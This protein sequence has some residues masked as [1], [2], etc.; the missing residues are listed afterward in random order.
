MWDITWYQHKRLRPKYTSADT[1]LCSTGMDMRFGVSRK[2]T[3]LCAVADKRKQTNSLMCDLPPYCTEHMGTA[4]RSVSRMH[5][6]Y[7]HVRMCG[8]QHLHHVRRPYIP[9]PQR[10]AKRFTS[11]QPRIDYHLTNLLVLMQQWL[12]FNMQLNQ[13]YEDTACPLKAHLFNRYWVKTVLLLRLRDTSWHQMKMFGC[14][15]VKM[16]VDI[17]SLAS[18]STLSTWWGTQYY[19]IIWKDNFFLF[20]QYFL[21]ICIIATWSILNQAHYQRFLSNPRLLFMPDSLCDGICII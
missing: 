6:Q 9:C 5:S 21:K 18:W 12:E 19:G 14:M 20:E 8:W 2:D 4:A 11:I 3:H 13:P 10:C 7:R 16:F 15:I 17:I 1:A